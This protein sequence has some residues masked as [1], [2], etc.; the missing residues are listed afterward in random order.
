MSTLPDIR[1]KVR[2][3]IKS[4]SE[5]QITTVEIDEYINDF[6]QNDF[7]AHIKTWNLKTILS[8]LGIAG[9]DEALIPNRAIYAFDWINFTNLEAPFYVAGN[10]IQ[11]FQNPE[12]FFNIFN[13][14]PN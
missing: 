11:L 2:R 9:G 12:A 8:P 4:P 7:P 3:I 5:N 13:T 14:F 6:Y 10:E 1:L